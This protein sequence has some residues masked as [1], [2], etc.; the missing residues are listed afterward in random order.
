MYDFGVSCHF[1]I[2]IQIKILLESIT[3]GV[4]VRV[5]PRCLTVCLVSSDDLF[6]CLLHYSL[7]VCS[8]FKSAHTPFLSSYLLSSVL[9][10][11]RRFRHQCYEVQSLI[12]NRLRDK[13]IEKSN[14]PETSF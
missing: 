4:S 6:L 5:A 11:I 10:Q 1:N 13:L 7:S 14:L 8:I 9:G 2:N 3:T 12:A